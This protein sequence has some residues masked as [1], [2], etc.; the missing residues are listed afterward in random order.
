MAKIHKKWDDFCDM[1]KYQE[2]ISTCQHWT[3]VILPCV[4]KKRSLALCL[5][6]DEA[7][8][9]CLSCNELENQHS[10]HEVLV[11]SKKLI[12]EWKMLDKLQRKFLQVI[13]KIDW[14]HRPTTRQREHGCLVVELRFPA[15]VILHG[16]K[17][18]KS[19][20]DKKLNNLLQ[21]NYFT[22]I[23]PINKTF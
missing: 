4:T 19:S 6:A 3:M 2:V 10:E 15:I 7:K 23:N 11:P 5:L 12:K 13:A 1:Y 21:C 22:E 14:K 9:P 8:V 17:F 20:Y 18:H 16:V